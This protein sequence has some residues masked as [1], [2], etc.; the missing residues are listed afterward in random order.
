MENSNL[1]GERDELHKTLMSARRAQND[2]EQAIVRLE[3]NMQNLE[4]DMRQERAEEEEAKA[5]QWHNFRE[6]HTRVVQIESVRETL[7]KT[8]EEDKKCLQDS[9]RQRDALLTQFR[10][11]MKTVE[12]D[13]KCLQDS[14]RQ[15]DALLPQLRSLTQDLRRV[16][17][18]D[19]DKKLRDSLVRI[20]DAEYQQPLIYNQICA[21]QEELGEARSAQ[22]VLQGAAHMQ[23]KER[24]DEATSSW[25]TKSRELIRKLSMAETEC[26]R[27]DGQMQQL[28]LRLEQSRTKLLTADT[29]TKQWRTRS[30]Q[31][32][33]KSVWLRQNLR[34]MAPT[35]ADNSRNPSVTPAATTALNKNA[36]SVT[37]SGQHFSHNLN[38]SPPSARLVNS[39]LTGA[40]SG[41]DDGNCSSSWSVGSV[42]SVR[43]EKTGATGTSGRGASSKWSSKH[44]AD[45]RKVISSGGQGYQEPDAVQVEQYGEAFV[46]GAAGLAVSPPQQQ[47]FQV[48]VCVCVC[49]LP[50]VLNLIYVKCVLFYTWYVTPHNPQFGRCYRPYLLGCSHTRPLVR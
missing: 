50:R 16:Q 37:L 24:A 33:K 18:I 15:R 19:F 10:S 47:P 45:T 31:R 20:S 23:P 28:E 42:G 40:F 14:E 9:E 21:L 32:D 48:V 34:K 30:A 22:G 13:K 29:Q 5:L 49:C 8:V 35:S 38:Q 36:S 4:M 1:Q 26:A 12:E 44:E 25:E 43:S 39:L 27:K 6:V 2:A 3:Q 11:L 17:S 46:V 7:V 41:L